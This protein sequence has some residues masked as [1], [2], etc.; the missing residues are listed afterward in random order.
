MRPPDEAATLALTNTSVSR[1]TL[2][3]VS[4]FGYTAGGGVYIED[5]VGGIYE[6]ESVTID[7]NYVR[8]EEP[9][10]FNGYNHAVGGG[11]Y[12]LVRG[13]VDIDALDPELHDLEQISSRRAWAW[14]L[15]RSAAE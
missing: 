12:L 5:Q 11:I 7:N 8:S 6:F 9:I 2:I 13:N 4:D 10:G 1:N 3:N 15:R 14:T